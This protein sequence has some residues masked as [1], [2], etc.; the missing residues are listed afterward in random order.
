M[1]SPNDLGER[2]QRRVG[3]VINGKY[4]LGRVLGVGGMATVYAATHRNKKRF[5]IKM[6]H[7]E[8]GLDADVTARFLREGYVAN[9]VGHPGTVE[10]FDDDVTP[11]GAPFLVME[12][13]SGETLDARWERKDRHLPPEE[14]LPI[15]DQLLDVLVA[16]HDKGIVHRDLKPE[17]LFLTREGQLKV[18]DFGIARL[19]ELSKD[20]GAET[21]AGS[22]LGTPAFMA[23]E[24]SRGRWDEVDGRTDIWAVGAVLFTTLSGS[25]VHEA[26]TINEQLIQAATVPARS[27]G[28][29]MPGLPSALVDLV[30]RALAYK[31]T[32]RWESAAAMQA[33]GRE[34]MAE[35]LGVE[36]PISL[37]KPSVVVNVD[38]ETLVAPAGF[39]PDL[40]SHPDAALTP[41]PKPETLTTAR[42]ITSGASGVASPAAKRGAWLGAAAS[43]VV[44]VAAIGWLVRPAATETGP[45]PAA[46]G[47]P[48]A[49]PDVTA[50]PPPR[51]EPDVTVEHHRAIDAGPAAAA[52]AGARPRRTP[53]EPARRAT[54]PVAAPKGPA[55]APPPAPA[56]APK[57]A[58]GNPFDRRH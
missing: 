38:T 54:G 41:L 57:A 29:V 9:T 37:P 47:A 6:L 11:D 12:L 34:V 44:L 49:V 2:A 32:D 13:L 45:A 48:I 33:R 40:A 7:P 46:S 55:A 21:K 8:I 26:E 50:A 14:V 5:A 20:S 35:L 24:Q 39:T 19:R 15:V 53:S 31:K 16:A 52:D 28:E 3:A 23:P 56:P 43:A 58:S 18:L 10:V 25:Y 42:A 1:T 30:D 4:A 27:L 36:G 51:K 22:L 17:N